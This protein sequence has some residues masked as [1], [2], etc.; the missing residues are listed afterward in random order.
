MSTVPALHAALAA[1]AELVAIV[2]GR[3]FEHVPARAPH[4][5]VVIG[6]EASRP[7]STDREP[8]REWVVAVHVWFRTARRHDVHRALERVRAATAFERLGPHLPGLVN[9]VP[10]TGRTERLPER[11]LVHGELRLRI[12]TEEDTP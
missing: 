11:G 9:V 10:G 6:A 7:W 1:D 2:E 3:V 8:G 12:R 4:P 5:Y